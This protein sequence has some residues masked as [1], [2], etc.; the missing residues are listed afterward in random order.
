MLHHN[1]IV[2][3]P[4]NE[5]YVVLFFSDDQLKGVKAPSVLRAGCRYVDSRRV[6]A[7]VPQYVGKLCYISAG[8]VEAPGEE[9]ADGGFP[10]SGNPSGGNDF[11]LTVSSVSL[12][13]KGML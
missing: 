1:S 11:L 12:G 9:A 5:N 13:A 4:H 7:A 3:I 6:D 2:G 10:L 8:F